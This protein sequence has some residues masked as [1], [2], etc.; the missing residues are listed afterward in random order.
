[1]LATGDDGSAAQVR[2]PAI[3]INGAFFGSTAQLR[4]MAVE[5]KKL[6]TL[7]HR[8]ADMKSK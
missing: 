7:L 8:P 2:L 1:M 5:H 4:R 3:F 6:V